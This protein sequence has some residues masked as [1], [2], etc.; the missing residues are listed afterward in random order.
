MSFN[1][2]QDVFGRML[3]YD[4]Q[5]HLTICI[6]GFDAFYVEYILIP[7]FH[8]IAIN[9]NAQNISSEEIRI[10]GISKITSHYKST[11]LGNSDT[12]NLTILESSQIKS[13]KNI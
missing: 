6:H 11:S 9:I 7:I 2:T 1:G 3:T 8:V 5:N 10:H 13:E 12:L 4:E